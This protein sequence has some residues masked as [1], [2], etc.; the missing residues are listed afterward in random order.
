MFVVRNAQIDVFEE[1][2][3]LR[4]LQYVVASIVRCWPGL[5][6]SLGPERLRAQVQQAIA[7]ARRF[8]FANESHQMKY[9]NVSCAFGVGFASDG[10]CPWATQILEAPLGPADRIVR[11]VHAAA[12]RLG[13]TRA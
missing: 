12:E 5:A 10:S 9:V 2:A 8:G 11:L 3:E 13:A 4:F 1:E 6:D 7:D